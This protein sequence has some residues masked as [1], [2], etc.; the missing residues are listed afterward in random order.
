M[1]DGRRT[2]ADEGPGPARAGNL[3][4]RTLIVGNPGLDSVAWAAV[5]P[6]PES[7]R[8]WAALSELHSQTGLVSIQLDGLRVDSL[9]PMM[10]RA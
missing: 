10:G 9:F 4:A 7:G 8:F 2:I 5:D 6:V 1:N 3:S